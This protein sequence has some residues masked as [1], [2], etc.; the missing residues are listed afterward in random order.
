MEQ[1][2]SV[3]A[4]ILHSSL[5]SEAGCRKLKSPQVTPVACDDIAHLCKLQALR[6]SV[7]DL[8]IKER[9]IY[10]ALASQQV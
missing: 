10:N 5:C 6:V 4:T 7:G 3:F 8:T 2:T 9:E 1:M